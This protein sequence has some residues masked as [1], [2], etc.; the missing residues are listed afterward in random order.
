MFQISPPFTRGLNCDDVI[1]ISSDEQSIDPALSISLSV[2]G[3]DSNV[4]DVINNNCHKHPKL[5]VCHDMKGNYLNDKWLNGSFYENAF[6]ILH[7]KYVDVFCYFSH[8]FITI[9]PTSYV[10][11]VRGN[12]SM[13]HITL[14]GT[15]ITEWEYGRDLCLQLFDTPAHA[16]GF[17]NLLVAT[18]QC[19]HL[20][21]W[22]VNI[23]NPI[24]S[25]HVPNIIVFLRALRAGMAS[26]VPSHRS[27]L[28]LW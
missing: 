17:A 24:E 8:E 23:E 4:T 5:L 20:D 27:S 26:V 16:V 9:P 22:L 15:V 6:Q 14:I 10:N 21:G 25:D 18:A 11:M 7:W 28:V 2:D 19:H 1:P 3:I 13:R 12:S